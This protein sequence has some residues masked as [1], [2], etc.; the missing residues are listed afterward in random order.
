MIQRRAPIALCLLLALA[1]SGGGTEVIV[2]VPTE[3]GGDAPAA[4]QVL[5]LLP[6]DRDSVVAAL[7]APHLASRPDTLPM[8]RLFDSLRVAY[9]AYHTATGA[10]R[11]AAKAHLDA[12]RMSSE[13]RLAE[14]R[15]ADRE[16]RDTAY[17]TY[18]SSTF[19][20]TKRL[21]RDP[22]A[23]TTDLQG[24]TRIA[25]SRSGPWWVTA[26]AWDAADPNAEWYWNVPLTGDTVRLSS[27]NARH[28]R[29][30]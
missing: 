6:Y 26:T 15:A 16:W 18:D 2:S 4:E 12:L 30:F 29:R 20:L 24:R 3:S 8:T 19:A 7:G 14:L 5:V 13:E 23:D 10:A 11:E 21:A 22:F 9:L 25:P 28:R 17:R 1:C 27:A